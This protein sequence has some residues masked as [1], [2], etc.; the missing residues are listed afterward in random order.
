MTVVDVGHGSA[1]VIVTDDGVVIVDT[2]PGSALLEYLTSQQ[3][4]TIHTVILSHA[5]ADHIRGLVGLLGARTVDVQ[6]VVVNADSMQGS[7]TWRDLVYELD[8]LERRAKDG[9]APFTFTVGITTGYR[10]ALGSSIELLA[11]GPRQRL[12]A[13]GVGNR[14]ATGQEI[15]S[16]SISAVIAVDVNGSRVALLGGDL[17][18]V[19][20][21]HLLD[22]ASARPLRAPFLVYPHHGGHSSHRSN[23]ADTE[24]FA[25]TLAEVVEPEVAIFSTS[26]PPAGNIRA[27]TVRGLLASMPRCRVVCT[28]LSTLCAAAVPTT[29]PAYLS[30][31]YSHGRDN[32]TCCAGT[33]RLILS[34]GT[35]APSAADHWRFIEAAAP[36]ALCRVHRPGSA[37]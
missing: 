15:R 10:H 12:A 36:T 7:T 20:L 33:V 9:G 4:T 32:H 18:D 37:A 16:N 1:T 3:L 35:L 6:E 21:A 27:E 11:L 30:D 8:A 28:Q 23:G 31:A 2:G 19:G 34:S 24:V 26:R 5:D 22:D 29:A 17:D 13:L 14:D 25:R